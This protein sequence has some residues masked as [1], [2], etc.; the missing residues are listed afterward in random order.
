MEKEFSLYSSPLS[1]ETKKIRL[2]SMLAS[3]L[4]LFIG[5]TGQLPEQFSLFGINFSSSEQQIV[6]W[7]IFSVTLYI[8]LHFTANTCVELAKWIHP[9]YEQLIINKTIASHVSNRDYQDDDFDDGVESDIDSVDLKTAMPQIERSAEWA[10][11]KK[12]KYLYKMVYLKL[13]IEVFIPL[14]IAFFGLTT[15]YQVVRVTCN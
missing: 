11:K 12:F 7:F 8:F 1:D 5:L 10:T 4:S 9:F 15:L 6:G 14:V 2:N 13:L 3:G